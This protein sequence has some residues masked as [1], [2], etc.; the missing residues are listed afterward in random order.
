M[1]QLSFTRAFPTNVA[2]SALPAIALLAVALPGAAPATTLSTLHSFCNETNCTDG[3]KP[4]GGLLMDASGNLYGM[5]ET[6]GK[7]NSGLVFKLIPN[8]AKTKYT[9][10]ILHNFCAKA[11]C[12]DGGFPSYG[13]LIMDVD[14]NLYGT[15]GGGGKFGAGAVFKMT[16]VTN[17]WTYGVVHSFCAQTNCP[18]GSDPEVGLAYAG[19]A[20]GAQWDEASPLFGSTYVGGAHNMGEVFELSFNGSTWSFQVIHSFSSGFHSGELLVDPSGNVV[21]TTLLGGANS[22]GMIFKLASG[23]WSETTLYNFCAATNCADGWEPSG[24]LL[25]D[26]GGNIF[27]TTQGGG[28]GA[29]C[30][31]DHGCGVAYALT[32]AGKY[33]VLYNFCSRNN[34]RDGQYPAS[35]IIKDAAG[36]FAGTTYGGGTGP[37]G[38]VFS[39]HHGTTWTE[40][41]LYD[42]CSAQNCTDGGGPTAP[43]VVDN[44]GNLFGTTAAGGANGDYGTVFEL[45]P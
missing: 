41:V 27:G 26:A 8:A 32:A 18:D 10:H 34:C 33:K 38:T 15:T 11:G 22:G 12:P 35:G 43:L 19:Q 14:G 44:A 28:A 29:Q 2:K 23:T 37:G 5:T 24:R 20:S 40:A 25:M 30:T 13:S 4:L 39:L 31:A 45:E 16:P 17:G 42:F 3:S 1:R 9:E 6:G 7:Y 36:D 21:G